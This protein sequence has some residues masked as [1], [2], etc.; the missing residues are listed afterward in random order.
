MADE[1]TTSPEVKKKIQQSSGDLLSG[2][3][4]FIHDWLNLK[5]DLDREGTIT[6]IQNNRK[7]RGANAWLLMCSIMVASLGLNLNSP[8][9]IIGAMLI[10]P[11]MSPILGI[12]LSVGINDREGLWVAVQ[13]FGMS[14]AIAL[15]TSVLYFS[16]TPI[17]EFTNEIASRTEP[18]FLDVLVAIFGGLAGIISG[19]R[20]DKS[21]AIPGVAIATALM[22]PLCVSGYG[23][24]HGEWEIAFN[25]FYLFFMNSTF[26]AMTTYLLVTFMNFPKRKYETKKERTRTRQVLGAFAILMLIPS[27]FIF[28]KVLT[29]AQEEQRITA[30]IENAFPTSLHEIT[31]KK[32]NNDTLEV[33]IFF[34]EDVPDDELEEYYR[35]L[36]TLGCAA[37]YSLIDAQKSGVTKEQLDQKT[38]TMR[39]DYLRQIE[40]EKVTLTTKK[41]QE[42][43][44]LEFRLDSL[45]RDTVIF[46]SARKELKALYPLLEDI[47]YAR[48]QTIQN[49]STSI[50]L[51]TF[52]VKW[53]KKKSKNTR[54]RDEERMTQ[55][56]LLRK[57]LD[58]L[59]IVE[60]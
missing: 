22:P 10:S 49:D 3:K 34:F 48:M 44:R 39:A 18:T 60:F 54:L 17:D 33:K 29:K 19:S 13:H 51:P 56:L 28:S 15:V 12:G 14:I 43:S 59:Q 58:T 47:Q 31:H 52:L 7:M 42:I 24:A 37:N 40:Q 36:R 21:N 23:L 35:Q 55:F 30:F 38:E 6:N 53:N 26:I 16:L 9:V 45:K 27:I 20:I 1:Q 41:D 50:V 25:A 11:L 5:D 32:G 46:K 2:L 4:E 57:N 8:A